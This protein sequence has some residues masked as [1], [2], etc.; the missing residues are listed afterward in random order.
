MSVTF[1]TEPIAVEFDRPP[2]FVRRPHCPQRIIWRGQRLAV[3]ELLQEWRRQTPSISNTLARMGVAR[4]YFRVRLADG[5]VYDIYFDPIEA[6]GRWFV[7]R[8]LTAG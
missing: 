7:S 2:P 4:I 1:I 5:R 6:R 3:A 8:E